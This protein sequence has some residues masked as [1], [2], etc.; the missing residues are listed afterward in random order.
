VLHL[1]DSQAERSKDHFFS[2][3]TFLDS[4]ARHVAPLLHASTNSIASSAID[5]A[6]QSTAFR[7]I[8]SPARDSATPCSEDAEK[9]LL[10]KFMPQKGENYNHDE[11][12]FE[13]DVTGRYDSLPGNAHAGLLVMEIPTSTWDSGKQRQ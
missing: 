10:S 9:W 12:D 1:T 4:T 8:V 6:V 2:P 13:T 11:I 7:I 5:Y 3:A